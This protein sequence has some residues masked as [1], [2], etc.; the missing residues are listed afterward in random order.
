M[1]PFGDPLACE[2]EELAMAVAE[3]GDDSQDLD[4][5]LMRAPGCYHG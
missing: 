1:R 5:I 4:V 3:E 2:A